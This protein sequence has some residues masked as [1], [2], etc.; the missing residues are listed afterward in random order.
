MTRDSEWRPRS[1]ALLP[2][3]D[4]SPLPQALSTPVALESFQL[5]PPPVKTE[6][7]FSSARSCR[8]WTL[9]GLWSSSWHHAHWFLLLSLVVERFNQ[10]SAHR[11]ICVL[12][13]F[14]F[15]PDLCMFAFHQRGRSTEG[16]PLV[17]SIGQLCVQVFSHRHFS[18]DGNIQKTAACPVI[19]FHKLTRV[20]PPTRLLLAASIKLRA[21][22][23]AHE[24]VILVM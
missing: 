5:Q 8:I 24:T 20:T 12:A 17:S 23:L 16:K 19:T 14:F 13:S 3:Q 18:R 4:K 15:F 2:G 7:T 1:G 22:V 21:L 10:H 11:V 6:L 9:K